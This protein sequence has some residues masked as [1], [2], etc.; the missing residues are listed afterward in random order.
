MQRIGRYTAKSEGRVE[1]G[2]SSEREK[3]FTSCEGVKESWAKINGVSASIF[4]DL[5]KDLKRDGR[6]GCS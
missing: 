5:M 4:Q 6:Y 1:L 2:E 3:K